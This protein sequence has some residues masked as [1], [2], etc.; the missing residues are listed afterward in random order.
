MHTV[1]LD[2]IAY[3][4]DWIQISDYTSINKNRQPC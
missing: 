4:L 3:K 1:I 2:N